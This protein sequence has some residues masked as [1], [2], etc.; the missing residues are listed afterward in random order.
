MSH[1]GVGQMFAARWLYA[2]GCNPAPA[3]DRSSWERSSMRV[4]AV[5]N[6][7]GGVGKTTTAINLASGWARR[8]GPDRVLLIDI[9][10]QANATAVLLGMEFAAGPRGDQPVIV[11]VL[12]GQQ[13]AAASIYEV[14]LP[15]G[16]RRARASTLHV[17]P[18][19]LELATCEVELSVAFRGEYALKKALDPIAGHYDA[20]VIDCPPSLGILTLNALVAATDVIIPV[21]P[22]VFPLIGLGL[23]QNTIGQ[24]QEA[25]PR[26]RIGGVLPTMTMNTVVS[27]ETDEQLAATYGD[28]LLPAVPRR[29]AVEESHI[30][31][32]DIFAAAPDS[33]SAVAYDRVVEEL[34]GRG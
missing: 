22:G 34:I 15:A 16:G 25:N 2:P 14:E 21:D 32:Q 9:D 26:L 12:R 24:V 20:I 31:G 23:L 33:D 7:K 3:A 27:R 13:P 28:L 17:L 29:V 6:Q 1:S 4:I 8:R 30:N 19:H 5:A 11:E 18:S 10:P